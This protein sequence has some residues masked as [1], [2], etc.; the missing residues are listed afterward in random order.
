MY[1][2]YISGFIQHRTRSMNFN[3]KDVVAVMD[4]LHEEH[5]EH[6]HWIRSSY[7]WEGKTQKSQI[8]YARI[9]ST[10]QNDVLMLRKMLEEGLRRIHRKFPFRIDGINGKIE[11][12]YAPPG[13]VA[14][15]CTTYDDAI[16]KDNA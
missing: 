13:K 15:P 4:K 2:L 14:T 9:Q 10:N 5:P 12:G 3:V 16:R 6:F 7:Q 8:W 1:N 11:M